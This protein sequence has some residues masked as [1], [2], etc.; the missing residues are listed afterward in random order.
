MEEA[1]RASGWAAEGTAWPSGRTGV[2]EIRN[3]PGDPGSQGLRG[4]TLEQVRGIEPPCSAWEADILPLNYTCV[5]SFPT[6]ACR[7]AECKGFFEKNLFRLRMPPLRQE[8]VHGLRIGHKK[9]LCARQAGMGPGPSVPRK[10][11]GSCPRQERAGGAVSPARPPGPGR[12]A[13]C[14]MIRFR[15]P[16]RI[17]RAGS[18]RERRSPAWVPAGGERKCKRIPGKKILFREKR[19]PAGRNPERDCVYRYLG[20]WPNCSPLPEQPGEGG[21][22]AP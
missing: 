21:G 6:I 20:E 14:G 3:F 15:R 9:L 10:Q 12:T 2:P 22:G 13:C 4:N 7:E 5:G 17:S 1:G 11:R 16:G 8:C 18:G 19:V